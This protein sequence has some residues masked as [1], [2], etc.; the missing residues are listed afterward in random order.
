MGTEL[1]VAC[2]ASQGTELTLVTPAAASVTAALGLGGGC[3][4]AG[5]HLAHSHEHLG[6]AEALPV[7]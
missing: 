1:P 6:K 2:R 7:V 5:R 3:P 4:A